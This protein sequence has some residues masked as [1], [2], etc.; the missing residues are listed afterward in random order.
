VVVVALV[1]VIIS[2]ITILSAAT[3]LTY[4]RRFQSSGAGKVLVFPCVFTGMW[5][6]VG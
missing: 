4:A 2:G 1:G 6:M 5:F 3:Y